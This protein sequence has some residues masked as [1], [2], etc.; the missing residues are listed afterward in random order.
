[1]LGDAGSRRRAR[2]VLGPWVLAA[3]AAW[4]ILDNGPALLEAWKLRG[5]GETGTAIVLSTTGA[6]PRRAVRRLW[7]DLFWGRGRSV[8]YRFDPPNSRSASEVAFV[9][10]GSTGALQ[11]G[12]TVRVRYL[13]ADPSVHRIDGEPGVL[14]LS[15]RL[16]AASVLVLVSVFLFL[17]A[18]RQLKTL[19]REPA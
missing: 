5:T 16:V 2:R 9:T 8:T 12:D 15:F 3:I 14:L 18:R 4:L 10:H 13:A 6:D 11:Q 1:M 7:D 19:S 17:G